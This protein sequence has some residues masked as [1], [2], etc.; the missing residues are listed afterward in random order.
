MTDHRSKRDTEN[1]C[2]ICGWA[3]HM[4]IHL[5]VRGG[6]RDGQPHGHA[7]AL[8]SPIDDETAERIAKSLASLA[9]REEANG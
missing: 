9:A 2:A 7:Y 3:R 4:A 1:P 8:R 5:P 6:P